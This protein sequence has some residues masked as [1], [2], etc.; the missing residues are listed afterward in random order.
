MP[1]SPPKEMSMEVRLLLAFLLMGVVMFVT[2]YFYKAPPPAPKKSTQTAASVAQNA[3]AVPAAQSKPAA[4]KTVQSA[5]PLKT[6]KH[7]HK[8][9]RTHLSHAKTGKAGKTHQAKVP[10][11]PADGGHSR[12]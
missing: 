8:T 10:G 5:K 11:K 12:A 9:V 1:E 7:A 2:P 3:P 4:G 6:I